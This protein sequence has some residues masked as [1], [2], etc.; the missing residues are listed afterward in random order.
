MDSL[1]LKKAQLARQA[2]ARRFEELQQV[3]LKTIERTKHAVT[4]D[5][6]IELTDQLRQITREQKELLAALG[7]PYLG[8]GVNTSRKR[9]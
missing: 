9:K 4:V 2:N 1:N 3:F 7:D 5:E 8:D 6:R